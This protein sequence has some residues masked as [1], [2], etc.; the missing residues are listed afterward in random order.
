MVHDRVIHIVVHGKHI[1]CD[2]RAGLT[3]QQLQCLS[4]QL[5]QRNV[6]LLAQRQLLVH[7]QLLGT[8]VQQRGDTRLCHVR[9]VSLCQAHR[10][11]LR[12]Q[13]MGHT[14]GLEIT[15]RDGPQLLR[16]QVRQV[17]MGTVQVL[18]PDIAPHRRRQ[19]VLSPAL[20]QRGADLGGGKLHHLRIGHH[21]HLRA[22]LPFQARALRGKGG[23][24][25]LR[26]PAEGCDM[27]QCHDRLRPAPV[28]QTQKHIRPHQQIQRVIRILLPQRRQ[29]VRGIADAAAPQLHVTDLRPLPQRRC[30][31]HRHV[32][33]L[34]RRGTALRQRL[35]GRLRV[36]D[37]HQLV[38]PQDLH[39]GPGRRHM[40]DMGRIKGAAVNTD[41]HTLLFALTSSIFRLL[42]SCCIR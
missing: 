29:R 39:G 23:G 12:A 22:E 42:L 38:Q 16:R 11:L 21:G 26:L 1:P 31:Q 32:V 27:G 37:Q 9:A 13:H 41:V 14:L 28:V 30:G 40:A 2:G 25:I 10:L 33:P 7:I 19:Q 8:V 17:R 6:I 18:P 4:L 35:V 24:L 3:V 5:V 36:R 34:P 20:C 15:Q